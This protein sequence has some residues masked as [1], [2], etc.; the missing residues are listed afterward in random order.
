MLNI[1]ILD[2]SRNGFSILSSVKKK[3]PK[4]NKKPTTNSF[5][6]PWES[7]NKISVSINCMSMEFS[8][9]FRFTWKKSAR[10]M[11]LSRHLRLIIFLSLVNYENV[12]AFTRYSM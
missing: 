2:C 7:R 12:P 8:P 11:A 10:S 9:C 4:T 6:F 3:K 5:N 1:F